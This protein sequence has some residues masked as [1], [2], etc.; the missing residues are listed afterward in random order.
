MA[1][2]LP[3]TVSVVDDGR[4]RGRLLDALSRKLSDAFARAAGG[5]AARVGAI[6]VE[7]IQASPE[8]ASLLSGE[9]R[10]QLGAVDAA[11]VLRRV[12]ENVAAGVRVTSLGVR[13]QG[14]GLSGGMRVALVK[15]DYS[16]VLG[17][18]GA[19]FTSEGGFEIPWLRWLTLEGDA[20]L[21]ADHH[22]Q[23]G[24]A[25]RS[26]TGLGI[27]VKPGSWRVPPEFS[28]TAEDNWILRALADVGP[29]VAEAL[30]DEIR[31]AA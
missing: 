2:Y 8:Y 30:V 21:V 15:G 12:C 16:E 22:F 14:D 19:T 20:I 29:A 31:K 17:A 10:G 1:S 26:R 9:L 18:E 3:V 11:A 27:M 28:G 4:F 23:A 25:A 5:V 13:R 24:H 6:A 7:A